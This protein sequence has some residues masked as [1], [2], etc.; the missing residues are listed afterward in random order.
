MAGRQQQLQDGLVALIGE[1][2]ELVISNAEQLR[3]LEEAIAR[4]EKELDDASQTLQYQLV[5][6]DTLFA[7]I[8]AVKV[9]I[10]DLE[11]K[12]QEYRQ[13][14]DALKAQADSYYAQANQYRQQQQH[15]TNIANNAWITRKGRSGRRYTERNTPVYN[16]HMNIANQAA[17]NAEV[18]TFQGDVFQVDYSQV[19]QLLAQMEE[20]NQALKDYE[21]LLE[22]N[23]Q[24]LSQLTG[25]SDDVYQIL[26]ALQ[27][28]AAEKKQ[29]AEEYWQQAELAEQRRLENQEKADWHDPL[30]KRWEVVGHRKFL[31][32]RLPIY[33]WREY[34]E[35]IVARDQAQQQ[36]NNAEQERQ[37]FEQWARQAQTEADELNAEATALG[38]RVEDWP[39]LKRGIQYEINAKQQQLQAENDL[40]ALQTPV[41]RQQLETLELQIAQSEA[42]LQKLETEELPEQQQKTDATEERLSQVQQDVEENQIQRSQTQ[43]DLQ[44]FLETYGYLLPY[45]ERRA[46][47]QK[48]IQQLTEEITIVQQLSL[49]LQTEVANNPNNNLTSQLESTQNYLEQIEQQLAWA[50]VQEEQ[51]NLSAPDSP[52]RLAIGTLIDDLAKRQQNL[53]ETNT[54]PLQEYIDFLRGVENRNNNLLNGFDDLEERLTAATTQQTAADET[55]T[56]LQNEY[57]DL[58][59]AKADIETEKLVQNKIDALQRDIDPQQEILDGYR[60]QISD[61]HGVATNFEELR[62]QYQDEADWWNS[63]ASVFNE[64]SYL[65]HNPNVANA[66]RRGWLPNAW[67]HYVKYGQRERRLP[68]PQAVIERDLAL[69]AANDAAQQRDAATLQAQQLEASLQPNIYAAQATIAAIKEKQQIFIDIEN[70][71]PNAT[72][73]EAIALKD[74][75]INNTKTAI[76]LAQDTIVEELDAQLLKQNSDKIYLQET[77][78]EIDQGIAD[79]ELEISDKYEEI[80]LTEKYARHVNAEVDRLE[81]RVNLLNKGHSLEA[82]YQEQESK[83]SEAIATQ[84]A[85]TNQLLAARKAGEEERNQLLSLQSQ[86]AETQTEL[87]TAKQ[88]QETLEAAVADTQQ[89]LEFTEVQLVTQE[90]RLESLKGQDE[91]LRSA[92]ANFYQKAQE[93]REKIW[94]WDGSKYVYNEER[95]EE[96]RTYLQEASRLADQRNDLWPQI[97]ETEKKIEELQQDIAT[98]ETDIATQQSQL[99]TTTTDIANLTAKVAEIE[100]DIAPLVTALE[101]LQ[102][103]EATKLQ[104]FQIAVQVAETIGQQ[105]A[106]TTKKQAD[107][108]NRLIGFGVLGTE[109]DVDFFATQVGAKVEGFIDELENRSS[110]LGAEADKLGGLI[111]DW[112]QDL[113]KTNDDVSRQA[114]TD[115]I[116]E[117]IG[118]Q[119]NLL[120]RQ[121]ENQE[122]VAGLSDRLTAATASLENIRQQQELEI[123][124]QLNSNDERLEALNR[125]LQTETAAEKAVNED[126][127][128]A[129]AQLND[130]VRADLTASATQW[131]SQLQEGHQ[132]TKEIGESQQNLSQSVDDLIQYIEDNLAEVDGEHDRNLAN[133]RDAITTLG[134][135]APRRDELVAGETHLKQ[136]IE[137]LKQWFEQDAELWS[138]IAPIVERFGVE[139]E[140][141][142]EYQ[143]QSE[144]IGEAREILGSFFELER[145]KEE[146]WKLSEDYDYFENPDNGSRYFFTGSKTW[147]ASQEEAEKVGGNLV[148]IRNQ[149]EQDFLKQKVGGQRVWIGFNDAER[150]GH[151]RWV[152]GEPVTYWNFE[153]GEPNNSKGREDFAEIRGYRSGKWNDS[154][155]YE[156]R[157][158]LV[159]VTV[160]DLEQQQQEILDNLV[161]WAEENNALDKISDIAR[162]ILDEAPDKPHY[163]EQLES[164]SHH[165][166]EYNR[167]KTDQLAE[168]AKATELRQ[169]WEEAVNFDPEKI[170]RTEFDNKLVES[171]RADDNSTYNR[172]STDGGET[173]S[174]WQNNNSNSKADDIK[175]TEVDGQLYQVVRRS[176]NHVYVRHTDNGTDWSGW[177]DIGA[178]PTSGEFAIDAIGDR[179]VVAVRHANNQIYTRAI[180]SENW[181]PW[182]HTEVPTIGEFNQEII[183]GRLVQTYKGVDNR[184]YVRN[185]L[186][187]VEW[188]QW[189]TA[190]TAT[191]QSDWRL[192]HLPGVSQ[193]S[194]VDEPEDISEVEFGDKIVQSLTAD[195]KQVY[196]RHSSDGGETWTEWKHT[197]G[198]ANSNVKQL[199]LN[200]K[201]FQIIK[202][203][204]DAV[205]IR[206]SSN[207]ENWTGWGQ[208]SGTI[209]G[210]FQIEAIADQLVLSIRGTDNKI[211]TRHATNGTSWSGWQTANVRAITGIQQ[212]AVDDKLVQSY[213]GT[214]DKIYTR[215][216]SDGQNWSTWET[217]PEAIASSDW[218]QEYLQQ[219]ADSSTHQIE[220]EDISE[221]EF[222][223]KI[224]QSR[225][226]ENKDVQTRHSTDGGKTW[227]EW[228]H[229]GGHANSNVK[230][231]TLN[232]KV[233]QVIKGTDDAVY[234]RNSTN[235]ENWTGW[236][237]LSGAVVGDFQIEAIANKLVLATRGTDNKIRS[238]YATNNTSGNVW[239]GWH[240]ASVPAITAI[241]QELVDDKLL[242]SYRGT[243]DEIYT[244]YSSDGSNW[245]EWETLP[246]AIASSDWRQE[247]LQQL[248]DSSIHKDPEDISEIEFGDKIVQSRTAENKDVQT[249]YSTDGGE[250]WTDWKD[251]GGNANSDV[252]QLTLNGKL[253]QVIK[254]TNDAV[255]IRHAADWESP[256]TPLGKGGTGGK[257]TGWSKLSNAILGDF[258][259]EAIDD[260]LVLSIRSTDNKIYTRHATNGT[261]WSGWEATPMKTLE[262]FS[263][264]IIDGKLVQSYLG[265]DGNK[266][267]RH[268][269]DGLNWSDWDTVDAA[270]DQAEW[271]RDEIPDVAEDS[272]NLDLE[273]VVS[274][275]FND[276]TVQLVRDGGNDDGKVY[277][278]TSS[279]GGKTWTDWKYSNIRSNPDEMEILATSDR[280]F[281]V[282]RHPNNVP[283]VR[284]STDGENWS[285]WIHSIAGWSTTG[286][287][288]VDVIDDELVIGVRHNGNNHVHTRSFNGSR[289]TNWDSA[290]YPSLQ[291]LSQEV[292]DDSP[293]E[294]L[295]ERLIQTYRGLNDIVYTRHT[296]DGEQWTDWTPIDEILAT[297]EWE[298][299]NL[300][301]VRVDAENIGFADIDTVEFNGT[302]TQTARGPENKVY[303][304]QSTDGG[305]TWNNWGYISMHNQE[306]T[307]RTFVLED[308]I[309]QVVHNPNNHI[310]FRSTIDG[311]NWSSWNNIGGPSAD[312]ETNLIDNRLVISQQNH[313]DRVYTRTVDDK[314][315]TGWEIAPTASINGIQ[316]EVRD[317]LIHQTYQGIDSK[318]YTRS[319]ADGMTWSSW[320]ETT[321]SPTQ[322]QH[323][324]LNF[325]K[326]DTVEFNGTNTQTA[327]G[328]ENKVYQRQSTDGGQTWSNW[329]YISMHNQEATPRTFVLEDRIFQV[330][331]NPN[332]HIYFR[333]TIDGSNWSSWNN[334]GGPSADVE[335]TL[336]DNRLVISQQNHNDRIY[337]RT[338]DDKQWTGWEIAP[339]A[340]ING[341][342]QEVRDGLI[343]QTYQGIDGKGYTRSSADGLTWSNWTETTISPT[344]WQQEPLRFADIDTVE[345]NGTTTQTARGPENK[346]YQ[347]QS[348]DGGQ[349]WSNWGYISMHNQES[350][351]RTFVLEDRV[352]QVVH[353]P[354]NR[355]YF[356]STGDGRNWSGWND[357]GSGVAD[358]KTTLIDNRLVIS[359]QNH[360]DRVY[361]RTVDDK[362][363]TNWEIAPVATTYEVHQEIIDNRLVQS[364]RGMDDKLY[365]RHS[366]DG[367][368]WSDWTPIEEVQETSQWEQQNVPDT[369]TD[370][371][372]IAL[373]HL[374]NTDFNDKHIQTVSDDRGYVYRRH[375]V[376]GGDT[377]TDWQYAHIQ[378]QEDNVRTV[379]VGDRL[380]QLQKH[381]NNRI[382]AYDSLDGVNWRSRGAVG[383]P[384]EGDYAIDVVGEELVFAMRHASNNQIYTR[385][386][387]TQGMSPWNIS[388]VATINDIQQTVVPPFSQGGSGGIV[389]DG[390]ITQTYLGV[391]NDV[392]TRQSTDGKNWTEWHS[393]DPKVRELKALKEEHL[394]HIVDD[395]A[396]LLRPVFLDNHP[397]NGTAIDVLQDE[398]EYQANKYQSQI[399]TLK[400][401]EAQ[402]N[403]QAAAALAQAQWY[404][405]QAATHWELSRKNGPTWT[406][407]RLT[408]KRKWYGKKKKHWVTIT[409]VDHHWILW[410]TYTKYAENLRKQAVSQ[411]VETDNQSQQQERF[412]PLAEQWAN[413]RNAASAAEAPID[414]SRNLADSLAATREQIPLAEEQLQELEELLPDIEQL[415]AEAQK[416]AD[417]INAKVLAE[418]EEQESIAPE[419]LQTVEDIL[420]RRGDLNKQSQELQNKLADTEKWVEQQTVALDTE[421]E[422]VD[423][424]RQ[425]LIA[426]GEALAEKIAVATGSELTE[427]QTK[428][429]Q[430][431]EA[432]GLIENKAVVLRQQQTAFSQKRTLLTAENEVI[433]A[434]QRLLDA[435]LITPESNFEELQQQLADARAALAEA[436]R[437]A[438][439]AEASSQVLTAPLQEVQQ[440]LLA[441]NDEHL[442]AAKERQQILK[443]LL[444]ATELNAN[445][446]LEA[447]QKQQEVN[448]LE[449][450]ILQ[451]LQEVTAAGNEEAKHLLEVATQND[452]ATAAELYY[453]DYRDIASDKRSSSAG[454]V[455]T[456]EDRKLADKYYQ[457]M[458]KYQELQRLAQ[459]QAD[460]FGEIRQTAEAQLE[461]LQEQQ[462]TA[463]QTLQEINEQINQAQEQGEAK[464]EELAVAQARLDGIARIREQT[465]QTFVHLVS[466]EQLNLAQAQLEQEIAEQRQSEIDEAVAQRMEREQIELERQR[467]EARA[468]LE[469]LEQLQAEEELRQAV[470]QARADVGLGAV[471]GGSDS[472]QLQSDMAALLGQLQNLEQQ[473]PNL[474]DDVKALLAD[475]RGDIY[476]ALQGEEAE[477]IYENLL[478]VVEGLNEQIVQ[479]QAAIQEIDLEEQRDQYLLQQ[480]EQDLQLAIRGL[481][482][483]SELFK[484]LQAEAAVLSPIHAEAIYKVAYAEEAVELSENLANSSRDLLN[485]ILK[486]RKEERKAR[487]KS[488]V[489]EIFK[490]WLMQ[491]QIAAITLTVLSFMFPPLVLIVA[492][493]QLMI[494]AMTLAVQA[495]QAIYNGNWAAFRDSTFNVKLLL[496]VVAV[497][498]GIDPAY[499]DAAE[500]V[501]KAYEAYESGDNSSAIGHL[502]EA[503]ATVAKKDDG[504]SPHWVEFAVKAHR[505][506]EAHESGD[507]EQALAG[508]IDALSSAAKSAGY[509]GLDTKYV[510]VAASAYNA[511]EAYESGDS[512]LALAYAIE[513]VGNLI[514]P[515]ETNVSGKSENTEFSFASIGNLATSL[516]K[517]AVNIHQGVQAAEDGEWTTAFAS[518]LKVGGNIDQINNAFDG[519]EVKDAQKWFD[520]VVAA[521]DGD[522]QKLGTLVLNEFEVKEA[523]KW[524]EGITAAA[525]GDYEK[526]GT[527]F[528]KEFGVKDAKK[529]SEGITAAVDGDYEKLG[530]LVLNEF[531]VKDAQK[532]S[533][534]ITAAID[535]DYQKLGTLVLNE[536]EVKDAQKW[537]EGITAAVDGDYR[538]LGTLVLKQFDVDN[539]KEWSEGV[540]A[541]VD[542]NYEKLG[543][544]VL[545]YFSIEDP[546]KWSK[547]IVKATEG[548]Y[549]NLGTLVLKEFEVKDAKKWSEGVVAAIDGDYEKLG[550]LVLKEFEVKDAQKWSKAVV[551]AADGDYE[552]L[553]TLVLD[554]FDVNNSEE[555]SE[556]IVKAIDGDYQNLG[557]LALK[558]FEVKD[559][560]KWSEGITAAADGDYEKLGTL[561]LKQFEVKDAQKWSQGVVAALDGDY[562]KLG[563][564]VLKQFEI[565]D[566]QKWSE[567]V[568]AALDGDYEKLGTLVLKQFDVD[569]PKEWSEAVV[570]AV[571]GNYEKLGTLT[572]D[573]FNIENPNKWSKA[574]VEATEG[575]YQK[576]GTMVLKEFEVKDAEQWS[577]AVIAAADGDYE[578]LGT[579]VLKEFEV[580]N[581]K[582]WSQAVAAATDGDYEKLGTMVLKEFEVKDA[583]QWSQAIIAAADGDSEKLE[584]LIWKQFGINNPKEWSEAITAAIDGNHEKLAALSLNRID[585]ALSSDDKEYLNYDNAGKFRKD[586][587][588]PGVE[589]AVA[590]IKARIKEYD[591]RGKNPKVG[592]DTAAKIVAQEFLNNP[593]ITDRQIIALANAKE[594]GLKIDPVDLNQLEK[595]GKID[596]DSKKRILAT[597]KDNEKTNTY[598]VA[599]NAMAILT[600]LPETDLLKVK[601]LGI[602]GTPSLEEYGIYWLPET[603]A[604]QRGTV[605][606]DITD[607]LDDAFKKL[608]NSK[609]AK[610]EDFKRPQSFNQSIYGIG[611]SELSAVWMYI[612]T[613][614]ESAYEYT[615][616]ALF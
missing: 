535:G 423:N 500:S 225:T 486:Q 437:L 268:S 495:L 354:N 586:E 380:F 61:A 458:L 51:L 75:Q 405:Q 102:Q 525:D 316:Q 202:G 461:T 33:G 18:A 581:A 502:I 145:Q 255:Y 325:E 522:Y 171:V 269:E 215:Y 59:L 95:A 122:I 143:A 4:T 580:K 467:L 192:S 295:R 326:V 233:Y 56:R 57:R 426:D 330:V 468:K 113:D 331:H 87:A 358:V 17:R 288:K 23:N 311:S 27:K 456:A 221:I 583:E 50:K 508:I 446:T 349:T 403:A 74:S 353:N 441:Q 454:G 203:T 163:K 305:Q 323:E 481:A 421:T 250:T 377:W 73:E 189:S 296:K 313:N 315:W 515:N 173:W 376:D 322:W 480:A 442:Q 541:A 133:L 550:T 151:W 513:G 22:S 527:L 532:W 83:W 394:P 178:G 600:G 387:N 378:T 417:E 452:M 570:A 412:K 497:A 226:A 154:K 170:V 147:H 477:G 519:F 236:G 190:E 344:Q 48:Q 606:H 157:R 197:G 279:D 573:Y 407:R 26:E 444:E 15:H 577:Q 430:L 429:A 209:L 549:Q 36:A 213:R 368:E 42:D 100:A 155:H 160:K 455:G 367:L 185:S 219:L 363:W 31:K 355:I 253:F 427:L 247:Y 595:D 282:V 274:Y 347:R 361:T 567:G 217:L 419:Y 239:S 141:L 334:I 518:L 333:S 150:E 110:E 289:W 435:Y 590:K 191:E 337:T 521:V 425:Q 82:D 261:S 214:D 262:D 488:F 105:L 60:Q 52:Q 142:A 548:D 503:V 86:L 563:T 196:T 556:A 98:K 144:L 89:D 540:V 293:S 516:A 409:H 533:E 579:V 591:S 20:Q 517:E 404:E 252:T 428:Q 126:T 582:Q 153:R 187:G 198:H 372:A 231:L 571:N 181:Q 528:L 81:N 103:Q 615:I 168:E 25:Q 249:R 574:I 297:S 244:R 80:E 348:T 229:T 432:L 364:Y 375:S 240:T 438:E 450:Q 257:W 271:R 564:L 248:A 167:L 114:L 308:R 373:E 251:T 223:D 357:V 530:T 510:K 395:S 597:Q 343:H 365:T 205:Y 328:P 300:E 12:I 93:S 234:I 224:I 227:T 391:D 304:R 99:A 476:L 408:W 539:P 499:I 382:Y 79:K 3:V 335:T 526:L 238:R 258:Q 602:T 176:N 512:N 177:K 612:K 230:Q 547:A 47:V 506:Y 610:G 260:Q 585:N 5:D 587:D 14:S 172:Y 352:F 605:I 489:N 445:Y 400:A 106:T 371:E 478:K 204:N 281:Q 135:V 125:Q 329:G 96:Y 303:Q 1:R 76:S 232:N 211:H 161:K 351:P 399:A 359:Q 294:T 256:L 207:G 369:K 13:Q 474:P 38:E 448:D 572:L 529:W 136:E 576:L 287:F 559:A 290:S 67:Y 479:Y 569:N 439:Q 292:V 561:V 490:I 601:G 243:D 10:T 208:L 77:L 596:S 594:D 562:E 434:E 275:Q 314:Q 277:E 34:P 107:A 63:Q 436:Q 443:D 321:I 183:D 64:G 592:D 332:N 339:T 201:V 554:Y 108:L 514:D 389:E 66:V 565:K 608:G 494:Q 69:A 431:Q 37:I 496:K 422:Q 599:V 318:G 460:H 584:N 276:R 340:S 270:L 119:K 140:E 312:V 283:Y 543:T 278:R 137:K 397:E 482:K 298:Q 284:H 534:G 127:V 45:Q 146:R 320:T 370:F 578:K 420:E 182:N 491:L 393:R 492:A 598:H 88:E 575:D 65:T 484:K 120:Q 159:E 381:P 228:K 310:Y 338:V 70:I 379:E 433:L 560:Q 210:D 94:Y 164:L 62:Q 505:A 401:E 101:P 8:D 216:S 501:Y 49:Q 402:N 388:T 222:G 241:H 235:G 186:D 179:L 520:G 24:Q 128:L 166:A 466:L 589:A 603:A 264:K 319:S 487:R 35:H 39:E 68:N 16:H 302:T 609:E 44:N 485:Q 121:Q 162:Q 604:L 85:A 558:Q 124:S 410:D 149:Q 309:F 483:D 360:N 156:P 449:F 384:A 188:A 327:K 91:P 374:T 118:Q 386:V 538:K 557:T 614:P 551:A 553:G 470:N 493:L 523:Q 416:E 440:D 413:T 341:I 613:S 184:T 46:A 97:E 301:D 472:A 324:P 342:Q 104:E 43:T 457:E 212:E 536:F 285:G 473:Q 424:L 19:E 200:D 299:K 531:E 130:Q 11:D 607:V 206:N 568:V 55:L 199:T 611:N 9:E 29:Q 32:S 469:Q 471:A 273:N 78:A 117:T 415:L 134:V 418:W 30:T 193:Q 245:Q 511:Y 175:F 237:K 588:T 267:V 411:L 139:S 218:R 90:L 41:Q 123:R 92:E 464:E 447:A 115:S 509:E 180:N 40:L 475:A 220:P 71:Q 546:N 280:L 58:G 132:Q 507:K 263:Q 306:A 566:A 465:E 385:T 616:D 498:V 544:L 396:A 362:R 545:D 542:G 390:T 158:G 109:S 350:T 6:P 7:D 54:L 463:A 84:V 116:A 28:Q 254:G 346:V 336:I 459:E 406:E 392:Y 194:F 242:Q 504:E 414:G 148:T 195:N 345:F 2:D 131:V 453:R 169:G 266:H 286:D 111:A 246:E 317:G 524:S 398:T 555:W 451:R 272:N 356:R 152:S 138:E 112:Q 129:Y 383:G 53:P 165:L 265:T 552:K 72:L 462:E 21:K 259:V 174:D 307:P 291:D 537:S 593:D 366:S